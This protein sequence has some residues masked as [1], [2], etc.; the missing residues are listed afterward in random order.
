MIIFL[1]LFNSLSFAQDFNLEATDFKVT[2]GANLYPK[3]GGVSGEIGKGLYLWGKKTEKNFRYGYL[4]PYVLAAT[5]FTVNQGEVGIQIFPISFFGLSLSHRTSVRSKEF[6]GLPCGINNCL[7]DVKT[8]SL[9]FHLV[10]G[11]EKLFFLY[12]TQFAAT[13]NLDKTKNF[14]DEN[15][16][17]LNAE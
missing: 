2:V 11:Y 3:S 8:N 9:R 17:L 14:I 6:E 7:S 1:F 5:S 10:L 15:T 16:M 12:N 13:E 4:R